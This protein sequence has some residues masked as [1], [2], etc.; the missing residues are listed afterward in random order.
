M[1]DPKRDSDGHQALYG[2]LF[3]PLERQLGAIDP[4]TIVAL[5]GFDDGGPLNFCTIG[6]RNESAYTTYISC[7]LAVHA[8]Q[9]PGEH[10]RYE[11]LVSC[12]D[13]RWARSIL[14]EIGRMSLDI[15]FGDGHTLDIGAWVDEDAPIQG[16]IFE[17]VLATEIGGTE[18]SILRCIGITREEME[19]ALEQGSGKLLVSLQEAGIYPHTTLKRVSVV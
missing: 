15:A 11:L 2:Q 14:S 16:V 1:R 6:A 19:Y 10:G 12:D 13:E 8:G 18:Y 7:E 9:Q 17:E 3:A 5:I 4:H